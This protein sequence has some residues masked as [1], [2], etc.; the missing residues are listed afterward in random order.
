M[1]TCG[2]FRLCFVLAIFWALKE[3]FG[4]EYVVGTRGSNRSMNGSKTN[5]AQA[6]TP[7]SWTHSIQK[8]G[9]HD[10]SV[11][12][13]DLW[14]FPLFSS[15]L[16]FVKLCSSSLTCLIFLH[17][18][19]CSCGLFFSISPLALCALSF[20]AGFLQPAAFFTVAHKAYSLPYT[21]N[22]KSP[23]CVLMTNWAMCQ[24]SWVIWANVCMTWCINATPSKAS[25]AL[26]KRGRQVRP[27]ITQTLQRF[28]IFTCRRCQWWCGELC[29]DAGSPPFSGQPVY[30]SSSWSYLPL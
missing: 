18:M 19:P 24:H 7:T 11:W 15:H 27:Y 23:A 1:S 25:V 12:L 4:V 21:S 26:V 9:A 10:V 30:A 6:L 17:H 13:S 22:L 29:S 20:W 28:S 5:S 16:F 3:P 8:A 2:P 14:A